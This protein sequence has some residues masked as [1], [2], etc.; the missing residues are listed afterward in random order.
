MI[1]GSYVALIYGLPLLGGIIAD[2]YLGMKKSVTFG[3]IL[4][5]FGHLSMAIEGDPAVLE[6]DSI[7]RSDFYL[8][9]FFLSISLIAVGVGFLKANISNLVGALYKFDDQKRDSGF[10][11]FY[12]GINLGAFVATIVCAYLG[13]TFGWKY[14]FGVAG[15][16][17]VLG[18]L[19]FRIGSKN[20]EN[21]GLPQDPNLLES[22]QFGIKVEYLIYLSSILFVALTWFLFKVLDDFGIILGLIGL[23]V[24]TWLFFYIYRKC[25]KKERNQTLVMLVLMAFSVFFW[26]LFEQAA[27][28]VTLFTDRN[29]NTGGELPAG[30]FQ[31]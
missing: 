23:P 27:S 2:R 9:F 10:T 7:S 15:I 16:G 29:V 25:N 6:G 24:I 13:E 28:S 1:Y 4:L 5:V 18:L 22:K 19:A 17:M 20:L 30:M 12:M 14:G 21:V 11:I 3:A 8:N 31:H 26:A